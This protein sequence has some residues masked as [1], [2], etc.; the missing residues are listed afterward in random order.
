MSFH[1]GA[2]IKAAQR[3]RSPAASASIPGFDGA[4]A[5]EAVGCSALLGAF[6]FLQSDATGIIDISPINAATP[7]R[8]G[9][10]GCC[11]GRECWFISYFMLSAMAIMSAFSSRP[12]YHWL[13][14]K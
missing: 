3:R 12:P 2:L 14:K 6:A 7:V 11:L 10:G 8:T 1:I 9:R 5:R 4:V 13:E